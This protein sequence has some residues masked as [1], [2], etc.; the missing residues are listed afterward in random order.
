MHCEYILLHDQ[1]IPMPVI[2]R[3]CH[4]NVHHAAT[5][6]AIYSLSIIIIMQ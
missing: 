3:Q 5:D 1:S 4:I 2:F 6:P